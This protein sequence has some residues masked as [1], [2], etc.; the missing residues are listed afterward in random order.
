MSSFYISVLLGY[1]PSIRRKRKSSPPHVTHL[2]HNLAALSGRCWRNEGAHVDLQAGIKGPGPGLRPRTRGAALRHHRATGRCP[3]H[4]Q[5]WVLAQRQGLGFLFPQT[6]RTHG[7][8]HFARWAVGP[9][10]RGQRWCHPW[11]LQTQ[12]PGLREHRHA[13]SLVRERTW[14]SDSEADPTLQRGHRQGSGGA[15]A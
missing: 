4:R 12:T 9:D 10:S 7:H 13:H 14:D 8:P 2:R 5:A 11:G 1:L 3:P 15:W 6:A